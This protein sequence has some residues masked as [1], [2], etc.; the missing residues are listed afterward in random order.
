[1]LT[2]RIVALSDGYL[3]PK[4]LKIWDQKR[5][6]SLEARIARELDVTRQTVHK[7]AN[8]ADSKVSQAL[9]ETARLNKMKVKAVDPAIG[10]L[11]GFSSEFKTPA[12]ITFSARN[13]VQV[14]YKHEGDCA[15]CD[16]LENCRKTLLAEM[17]ERNIQPPENLESI[18]PSKIADLLFHKITGE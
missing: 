5:R 3:T 2:G 1:M 18:S 14:W 12:I 7:A 9:M 10:I 11:S 6:G 16:H 15:N 17:E 13:G 8:V 4:Q